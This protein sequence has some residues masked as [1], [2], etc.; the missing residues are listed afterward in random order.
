MEVRKNKR[1]QY[2]EEVPN[3]FFVKKYLPGSKDEVI[4]AYRP[5][6]MVSA[7][8]IEFH[9]YRIEK[10]NYVKWAELRKEYQISFEG[11]NSWLKENYKDTCTR[12][13]V[14]NDWEG[15]HELSVSS[16]WMVP[17]D[18]IKE[19]VDAAK[20]YQANINDGTY[21]QPSE[22]EEDDEIEEEEPSAE[23]SEEPSAEI[24]EESEDA[25]E[26]GDEDSL[27][28]EIKKIAEENK[29]KLKE[30]ETFLMTP[31]PLTSRE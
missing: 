27:Y 14:F 30:L 17:V 28:G 29:R 31:S 6:L 8:G 1:K 2:N 18:M 9:G 12:Q 13:L 26:E 3:E 21:E 19:V 4:T 25:S 20:E 16:R 10:E 11:M 5:I 22:G 23:I 24:S 15:R 7:E